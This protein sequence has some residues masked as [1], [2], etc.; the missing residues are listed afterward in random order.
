MPHAIRVLSSTAMKTTLEAIKPAF[1]RESGFELT[2][3]FAPSV[4]LSQEIANG[5]SGDAAIIT[6]PQID[7]LATSG[8]MV[9]GSRADIAVSQIGLAVRA[10]EPHPD[11]ATVDGFRQALLSA[12]SIGMS[13]PV[14]GGRSGEYLHGLFETLGIAEALAGKL[15]YGPG[16][17]EGLI[18]L[19]LKRGE[20]D[21]GLQQMPELMA[22]PGIDIVGPLPSGAQSETLFSLGVMTD[23]SQPDAAARLAATLRSDAARPILRA[24]GFEPA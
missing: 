6:A 20:V 3:T 18:G 16:G 5:L 24:N 11:I 22:V 9:P 1:E 7:K 14:G 2:V 10:G 15:F 21:I 4:R 12:R 19:Y 17:P 8:R 23:C 13:N